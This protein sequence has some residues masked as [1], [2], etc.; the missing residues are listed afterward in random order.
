M[1][2]NNISLR[3]PPGL[4]NTVYNLPLWQ[5][6]A[7]LVASWT[8]PLV[9]FWLLFLSPRLGEIDLLSSRLPR[10]RADIKVLEAKAEQIPALNKELELMQGILLKAMKLLPEKKD[11]PTVLTEISSIA[12]AQR[13]EILSFKPQPE[14]VRSFY[15]AIPV[16]MEF[17]GPFHNVVSFFDKVGR[18]G[19]I[20]HIK[21]ISMGNARESKQVW[22]QKEGPA[23][24][25]PDAK[26]AEGDVPEGAGEGK[27]VSRTFVIKTQCRVET[28]RF[29]T[30]EE[31]EARKKTSKKRRR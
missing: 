10:L 13:L 14:Q 19:R 28:Y 27:D 25:P 5:K 1:K 2:L 26:G 17:Q 12:N 30:P 16:E 18:M 31:Q 9:L 11:I 6:L 15:A 24:Q 22:S 21:E 3:I 29:L 23:G 4:F 20:V 7:I 8:V